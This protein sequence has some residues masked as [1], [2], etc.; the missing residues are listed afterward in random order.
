M[1][2]ISLL[3]L[4]PA[5]V[6]GSETYARE[7]CRALDR[8]G[9]LDY[10]VFVPTIAEDAANG[11]PSRTVTAYRAGRSMPARIVAMGLAA[12][13]PRPVRRQL[14]LARLDA[15]HFPLTVMLPTVDGPPAVTT[16]LDVQH[17]ELPQFFS[18]PERAY[19]KVVYGRTARRSRLVIAISEQAKATIVDRLGVEPDRVRVIHL[20]IDHERFR[21]G[22][23]PSDRDPFLLYPANR[24]PHKNHQGLFA[25]FALLQRERPELRLVLTGSGHEGKMLPPGVE[26]RGRVSPEELVQLYQ[27]ATAVVFPSLHEGFG[28]PT[29]EAMACGCPVACSN[30]SALP[31]VVGGAARLFDPAN[32]DEI[33]AAVVDVL[34]NAETWTRRGLARAARFTWDECARRHEEVYRELLDDS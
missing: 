34:A 2:G 32:P 15:I 4:V 8:V 14:E 24:W 11:L 7:L 3:T 10:R 18:R 6:G 5:V 20:G 26:S 28:Q 31:E 17:E 9:R 30:A 21:P 33:A 25:A 12:V 19:R 16:I 1:V 13:R 23:A 29:L 27:R 22:L